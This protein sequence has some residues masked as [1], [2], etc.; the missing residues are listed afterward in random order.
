MKTKQILKIGLLSFFLAN[1][2]YAQ[3]YQ[4]DFSGK[5][6]V[7]KGIVAISSDSIYP[8][9]GG[10]GYDFLP[11]PSKNGNSPFFF[12]V[13]VP[14]GNYLVT[15]TLGSK[16]KAGSTTVRAES[17]R[18]FLENISTR[19]GEFLTFR[20]TVNKRNTIIGN[21]EKVQIKER[22]KNKLNW[23]DKLTFEFN[24]DAPCVSSLKIERTDD[25]LTVFLAG[26]ST[27]VDQD[28]EPWA[29]WGQM[30]PRF[31]DEHVCFAN[32]AESGESADT[33]IKAGRLKKALTQM[34][35]GD[36]MFIEFGHNDQKLKGP[37]KGAYYYFAT[38]L[39]YF[40]D[41]VREKGGIP[42]FVTPTQRRSFDEAGKI[43][44][45][46]EDYPDAMRWVAQREGVPVIELHDMTRTLYEAMGVE[47]S[48]KAFV[49][50]PAGTYPHQTKDLADNTHFN[51]YG[52]YEI[53]KCVV[54]GVKKL[55]LP[56]V[57][58]LRKDYQAFNPAMPD[59]VKALKWNES[60]FTEIEKPDGN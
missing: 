58:Y 36:Y 46:H 17:R 16:Q 31:F 53:A 1:T 60:P 8:C 57:Q 2:A 6:K 22:E 3:N 15:V 26:N 25:V 5:K 4:F 41:V 44:E 39:K 11:A 23:D 33:F 51:P 38:N 49:H 37:G 40:V 42:V 14:D 19:K 21:G 10:Y 28:N 56:W 13:D 48:K 45:T 54:E 18:L 12:S 20:F 55:N 43:R 52:A 30:I 32:Y 9:K 7:E 47:A 35:K 24:G 27:V 29:S 59:E 34:K 50:Y